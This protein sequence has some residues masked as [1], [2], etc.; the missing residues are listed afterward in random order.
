MGGVR[1]RSGG[2][3]RKTLAQ[4]LRDGNPG[5]RPLNRKERQALPGE[6]KLP[7]GMTRESQAVWPEIV[8]ILKENNALFV[9]DGLAISA[10][11]SSFV[12]FRKAEAAIEQY[13]ALAVTIDD[14]TGIGELRTSPAV[15]VR[16]DALKHMRAGWQAFGLDPV[17]R[18]GLS[19][20]KIPDRQPETALDAILRAK[21]AGDDVVN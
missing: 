7:S 8:A 15:R 14:K 12:L 19:V 13:G 9:T 11:C 18:S 20:G 21:S 16:S 17:S 10:L 6:P 3:N 4:K 2:K 5:K 1:G